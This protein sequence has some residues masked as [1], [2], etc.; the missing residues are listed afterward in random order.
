MLRVELEEGKISWHHGLFADQAGNWAKHYDTIS[1][2]H[3]AGWPRKDTPQF[4]EWACKNK[5]QFK[6]VGAHVV[7]PPLIATP[8][9]MNSPYFI[10]CSDTLKFLDNH[11]GML[12]KGKSLSE[13][14]MSDVG[15][16]CDNI[17]WQLVEATGKHRHKRHFYIKNESNGN[18]LH[19]HGVEPD[20]GK[21]VQL[22]CWAKHALSEYAVWSVERSRFGVNNYTIVNMGSKCFINE[23]AKMS[24]IKDWNNVRV[25]K[26]IP[27]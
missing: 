2:L 21:K 16:K 8:L 9:K 12:W 3:P 27:A 11:S 22:T 15:P 1:S 14:D 24:K 7:H 13:A 5:T 19:A 25:W 6:I 18:F 10:R 17:Q 4:R 20:S 23:E 26:L